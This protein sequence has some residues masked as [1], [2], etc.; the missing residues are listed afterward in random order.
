MHFNIENLSY[1]KMKYIMHAH[2]FPKF[3][4]VKKTKI[5]NMKLLESNQG[6][7]Q[8]L[9]SV[10]LFEGNIKFQIV[11]SEKWNNTFCINRE[12]RT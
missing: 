10:E 6:I 12:V 11:S 4:P 8:W 3:N 2:S 1:A 9:D 7:S 5:A